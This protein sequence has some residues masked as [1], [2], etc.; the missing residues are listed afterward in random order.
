MKS[1]LSILVIAMIFSSCSSNKKRDYNKEKSNEAVVRKFLNEVVTGGKLELLDELW[2]QDMLWSDGTTTIRGLENF[3]KVLGAVKE[4]TFENMQLNIRDVVTSK[5]K[6]VVRFTN[7]GK[8]VGTY[9]G[10]KPTFKKA[11]WIGIGIYRLEGGKIAEA[12]FAED[13]LSQ[14]LQLGIVK[15]RK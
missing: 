3:R 11:E 15:L 13:Y 4:K 6:V 10:H 9:R 5:N 14:L 7:S 12:W 1:L 8:L 2:T